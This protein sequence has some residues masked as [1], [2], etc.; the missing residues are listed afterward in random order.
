MA[1]HLYRYLS[2]RETRRANELIFA[3]LRAVHVLTY[4]LQKYFSKG[5]FHM[6]IL[7]SL[8]VLTPERVET[9]K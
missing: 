3:A 2:G 1:G 9:E 6:Q 8:N 7:T 5:V 4:D